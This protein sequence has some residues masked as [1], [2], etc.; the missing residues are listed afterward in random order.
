MFNRTRLAAAVSAA[1]GVGLIAATPATSL[2]Q[3][4]MDRVE[5]T[6]SSIKRIEGETALPVQVITREDIQKTG[7]SNVEQLMLTIS[8]NASSGQLVGAS[9]SGATTLGLSSVSL[10][11]LNSTRTLVLINGRR[12]TPYGFGFVTDSVSVDINS[13][14]LDAIDRIEIL[15]DGAS[16][17]YGSDAI[18]GVVNFIL[19]KDFKGIE[20]TA[21]YG[22][23]T[24]NSASNKHA[25]L[26]WG[27]GDLGKD[28][29]NVM[30]VGS[31]T[32]EKALFGR[33]RSFASSGINEN[34]LNDTTSGNT[35]PANIVSADGTTFG[36]VNPS[37]PTCPPPY[38]ILDPAFFPTT[39]CRFDPSPLVTLYPDS[40]RY[41]VFSSGKF[42]LTPTLQLFAEASFFKS[43][44][45]VVIQP[46]PIS[47]QFTIPPNNPLANQ[48][49]YN[50]FVGGAPVPGGGTSGVPYST[51]LLTSASPFY[52]TTF[53]TGITGGATPD[54][55][56]RWRANVTGNRDLTDTSKATRL[57]TGLRG[58]AGTWDYEGALLYSG[59]QVTERV[60]DGFAVLSRT[61]PILNSGLVNFFGPGAFADGRD[62]SP[63][64]LAAL[65][66]AEMHG[67]TL[68]TKTS[69][70]SIGGKASSDLATLA[71]GPLSLA[72]GAELR[73][74]TYNLDPST[75]LLQ[76][77]LSGYGGSFAKVDKTR[78]VEAVFT[79]VNARVLQSLELN[80]AVRFD[81]YG[82]VGSS[83]TPKIGLRY[84]PLK[85][86]LLRA[87]AGRGFRAPSLADLH[88]P[89]VTG[90]SIPGLTDPERCIGANDTNPLDCQTQFPVTTG[91]NPNLKPE[92]SRNL[93]A[94]ILLEPTN[95][96]SMA[97]DYFWISLKDAISN[98]VPATTI[99]GDTV[100]YASL[101]TRG[102]PTGGLPGP[103]VNIDQ[104]NLN[105]GRIDLSG[106]D[107]DLKFSTGA[108]PFGRF[109][110]SGNGT[111]LSKY[112]VQNPDLSYTTA[113]DTVNTTSGGVTVRWRHFAA[114]TWQAGAWTTSFTEQYQKRYTDL[115][116][117]IEQPVDPAVFIPR[118]VN[119]YD[120]YGVQT[121]WSGIKGFTI[122][123]GVRNLFD[124]PPPYTNAGGQ[125]SFQGGYDPS[126]GDPRGRF[127]YGRIQYKFL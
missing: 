126:Y 119:A 17:I 72:V 27:M 90:V 127:F 16:A 7:A 37:A 71:G 53:V 68:R 63:A 29:Y 61:L 74:E 10:R 42:D 116:G 20:A 60:N 121:A 12:V 94:G 18:A 117:T 77:D 14:P 91:G 55:L 5:I 64:T 84:Q 47:D 79:E 8:S 40:T 86:V 58:T 83:T 51:I 115:P 118:K 46:T 104:T 103:I 67:D 30:V 35:F 105:L 2:A 50:A 98:G 76:G 43:E 21:E 85:E 19:R 49:P 114:L 80:A 6:G 9:A 25:S 102:A 33:D 89:N 122:T 101:I 97:I 36:T 78:T 57:V 108:T 81:H 38:S 32:R 59:S 31:Y 125:T 113:L 87:S 56:V 3:Q 45:N 13:I 48:F 96:V 41:G 110:L 34:A 4:T 44:S 23:A 112:D 66:A 22:A 24:K 123:L 52:P 93:T 124:A 62:T 15:K 82:N 99:L 107:I 69:L 28:R 120:I 106:W 88:S 54:L 92:K 70:T 111:Y 95:N 75:E 39:R 65:A 100:K 26:A 11:G 109:T 1:F 73:R